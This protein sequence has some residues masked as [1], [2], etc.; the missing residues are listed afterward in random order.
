MTFPLGIVSGTR[1]RLEAT[2]SDYVA[3]SVKL[4][5]AGSPITVIAK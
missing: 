4:H 3:L 5:V 1:I 2:F